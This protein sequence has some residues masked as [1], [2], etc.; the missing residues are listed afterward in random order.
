M[1]YD[2]WW[3]YY[4]EFAVL[5]IWGIILVLARRMIFGKLSKNAL[6]DGGEK[7]R[8]IRAMTL[9]FEKSYEVHVEI[10]DIPVFVKKYLCQERRCGV[11]L[12]RWK[13]LPE[14]WME[15]IVSIGVMEAVTFYFLRYPAAVCVDRL[16]A[17]V[18]A[19]VIVRMAI[20]WFET[21]SLWEQAEVFLNDYVAN[22]LYPRQMH[23]Y[24]TFEE[25]ETSEKTGAARQKPV[26]ENKSRT[27]VLKKE[28]EQ[29][30]QEVMTEF[31][32]G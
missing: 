29:L 12:L 22:T 28:E 6:L 17:S 25:P 3:S 11:R 19:A 31:L 8:M 14:R 10:S 7:S 15:L 4:G 20:L 5:G 1:L 18:G 30:L 27:S 21:D 26:P 2:V 13:R 24:E 16:L 32:G 9:K 23:V